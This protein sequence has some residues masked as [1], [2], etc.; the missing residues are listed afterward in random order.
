MKHLA[1][2]L[3]AMAMAS[4]TA[5]AKTGYAD[6]GYCELNYTVETH[7]F[8]VGF[9]SGEGVLRCKGAKPHNIAIRI[10]NVGAFGDIERDF[11]IRTHGKIYGWGPGLDYSNFL[12]ALVRAQ[13]GATDGRHYKT[14][15]GA[16]A[17]LTSQ[18]SL[19]LVVS[20]E[21]TRDASLVFGVGAWVFEDVATGRSWGGKT[22]CNDMN[23][24]FCNG[25]LWEEQQMNGR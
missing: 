3:I 7:N 5:F 19:R 4:T 1:I 13:F 10:M 15:V 11:A 8:V 23:D 16:G 22:L 9:G 21:R 17:I 6:H 12:G 24:S 20:E 2:A 25:N 18:P 14:T